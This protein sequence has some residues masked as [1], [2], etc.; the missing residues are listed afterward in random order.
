MASTSALTKASSP[1]LINLDDIDVILSR[2]ER[3][4][5]IMGYFGAH[6]PRTKPTRREFGEII[7]P[8]GKKSPSVVM[9]A[10]ARLGLPSAHDARKWS[11]FSDI[12][13]EI[14]AI[15]GI[16]TNPVRFF[17]KDFA[18]RLSRGKSGDTYNEIEEWCD[19]LSATTM[20]SENVFWDK[21]NKQFIKTN[22]RVFDKYVRIK[23]GKESSQNSL[24]FEVYLE[25]T[26]LNNM[27]LMYVYRKDT[28][29]QRQLSGNISFMLFDLLHL[30]FYAS[31]GSPIERSYHL[32]CEKLNLT[33]YT[34]KSRI[35]N[36]VGKALDDL[37]SMDYLTDWKMV[38][39]QTSKGWKF[40]MVAG[41]ELN[42][43]LKLSRGGVNAGGSSNEGTVVE[44]PF[45]LELLS[46]GVARLT[47]IELSKL[48]KEEELLDKL[49]Y[50]NSIIAKK[51]DTLF[52][53]AGFAI[54]S[55][56][57][58]VTVPSDFI[59]SRKRKQ[60]VEIQQ[61]EIEHQNLQGLRAQAYAQWCDEKVQAEIKRL[62][63]PG[64]LE[65]EIKKRVPAVLV[66]YPQ[67]K[68]AKPE[69][70]KQQA[71][72]VIEREVGERLS[73]PM[74]DDWME[75]KDYINYQSSLPFLFN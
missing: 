46:L 38:P 32:I 39:M 11:I 40:I 63:K 26:L 27:N 8:N 31:K 44:S 10:P 74:E 51:R 64:E 53:P 41:T 19:R 9:E 70:L 28:A 69:V 24:M 34:H 30:W 23:S 60:I 66:S 58:G 17:A 6:D 16:V 62:Y 45:V 42:R 48:G 36:T 49:D 37:K 12:F 43:I 35:L 20:Y 71:K 25:K 50:I 15:N 29:A 47:A 18:E 21:Q 56:R 68:R 57:K 54:D 4:L 22:S 2:T 3:N 61:R 52:N 65:E 72:L 73:L 67:L 7:G 75:M 33:Q 59:T 13:Y 14:R 1:T 5:T 55:L